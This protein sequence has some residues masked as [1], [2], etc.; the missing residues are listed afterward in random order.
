MNGGKLI[1]AS[2]FTFA[3]TVIFGALWAFSNMGDCQ[4]GFDCQRSAWIDIVIVALAVVTWCSG[5][6]AIRRWKR[7]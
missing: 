3:V 5:I 6:V 7:D 2:W 4:R 1:A